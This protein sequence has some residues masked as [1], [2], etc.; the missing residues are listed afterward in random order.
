VELDKRYL[1]PTEV[2]LL[3]GDAAKAREILGWRARVSFAELVKMMV[4]H[5]LDLARRERTLAS[6]GY[7]A[8]TRGA[9]TS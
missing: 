3:Q 5:D 4:A 7:H 2:D 9:A 6:A 8:P 1:R